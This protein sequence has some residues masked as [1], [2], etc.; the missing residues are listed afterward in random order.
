[1]TSSNLIALTNHLWQSTLFA[2]MVSC[3]ALLLRKNS[4]RVRYLL[5]LAASAKFLVPFALLTAIGA[6]I[7]WSVGPNHGAT[8]AFFLTADQKAT[9]VMQFAGERAT[10]LAQVTHAANYGDVVLIAFELLWVLG[11]LVVATH[12][13]SRWRLVRRALHESTQTSLAFVIRVRLSSAQL[14]PAVVGIRRPVLLLPK[15][16]EQ[17]LTPEEIRAVLAHERCHVAWRDNLAATLH[18]IV[19]ALFWFHPLIWWLG[20]RIVDERERACDE[21]VLSEGHAPQS[22]AEGILKVCEH[23]LESRLACIAGVSGANLSER[24]EAIVKNR[25]I[26]R[27]SAVRKLVVT[28]AAC[29]T[30]AVPVGVGVFTSPHAHAQAGAPDTG[31]PNYRD[32]TIQSKQTIGKNASKVWFQLSGIQRDYDGLRSFIAD[33]YGV[34]D[35]QVAGWDWSKEPGYDITAEDPKLLPPSGQYAVMRDLLAKRFGLVVRRGRKRMDGYALLISPG[36]LK[37]RPNGGGQNSPMRFQMSVGR[38]EAINW[39]LDELMKYLSNHVLRAPVVDQTGLQGNYDYKVTWKQ[40]TPD[41]QPDP[42]AVAKALEEQLGLH[43]KAKPVTVDVINVVALKPS[44]S[45]VTANRMTVNFQDA[46]IGQMAAAVQMATHKTF[47]IDPRVHFPVPMQSSKPMSPTEFYGA[48]LNISQL[49][50]FAAVAA[51]ELVK[52]LPDTNAH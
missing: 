9:Q 37:L 44:G 10:S 2:V 6:Q 43:L 17:R 21:Q 13:F 22:Y 20:I 39:P 46:D 42:A 41:A 45:V 14:E 38:L 7:P 23:Y 29:A 48:C 11:T 12:W 1:V 40:F 50:G 19:E 49:H 5:W 32:V 25:S 27:L 8:P 52:I 36:G 16:I 33:A 35:S 34:A 4:A 18:M 28:L 15:G 31:E 47:V 26:E 51:G 24:I 30:I 3:L